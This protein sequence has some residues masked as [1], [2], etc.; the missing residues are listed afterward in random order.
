MRNINYA[1]AEVLDVLE[2]MD[3]KYV[4]LIPLKLMKLFKNNADLNYKKHIF[5]VKDL[6]KEDLDKNTISILALLNLKY[7][8]SERNHKKELI[9]NYKSNYIEKKN[10]NKADNIK[11]IDKHFKDKKITNHETQYIMKV[12][13][14][15]IIDTIIKWFRRILNRNG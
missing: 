13:K 9:D 7:W 14:D 15:S 5:S 2:N 1:Y 8:T 10:I 3:K 11:N 12:K 4:D 6:K